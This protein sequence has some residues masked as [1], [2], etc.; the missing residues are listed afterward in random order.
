LRFPFGG[1]ESVP[2]IPERPT[3]NVELGD[4]PIEELFARRAAGVLV[5]SEGRVQR[6]LADDEEGARHQRFVLELRSGHTVLVSHNID[7]APRV[8]LERGDQIEVQGDYEWNERGGVVHWTHHD[9]RGER[10]GG[11]IRHEGRD[12]R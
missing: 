12:Y 7:L 1:E 2:R 10:K 5:R 3:T 6:L 9:P 4:E 11:W 8:P